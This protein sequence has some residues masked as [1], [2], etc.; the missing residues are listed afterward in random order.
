MKEIWKDIEG[1]EGHYQVSNKGVVKSLDREIPHS[2]GGVAS[3]KGRILKPHANKC[4]GLRVKLWCE[5]RVK[6]HQIHRLVAAAYIAN[7]ENKPEVNHKDGDRSNNKVVNLE[8]VTASEN[9]QHSYDELG[10]RPPWLGKKGC[11]H[12]RSKAVIQLDKNGN[13]ISE[14]GS[15]LEAERKTGIWAKNIS[16]V[17]NGKL[18]TAGGYVWKFKT[19]QYF[20]RND[21]RKTEAI[22]EMSDHDK[23]LK[24]IVEAKLA[25]YEA[26]VRRE[27]QRQ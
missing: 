3:I 21:W 15:Q 4:G 7:P 1:Y 2:K 22:M 17:L 18:N 10:R 20:K 8:W 23:L 11:M 13:K 24:K 27:K 9:I 26:Q 19:A 5:G 16:K 6:S 25:L 14:Y 12:H